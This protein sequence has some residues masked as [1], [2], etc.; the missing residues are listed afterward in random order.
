MKIQVDRDALAD[1]VAWTARALP[2]RPAIPVLACM[3]LHAGD[4]LTLSSFDY[5]V[6][7]QASVP[8]VAEEEGTVLV[9]GRLLAEITRSLPARP[10]E[11]SAD[12]ARATLG[13][14]AADAP[15]CASCRTPRR[16]GWQREKGSVLPSVYARDGC[17]GA[18]RSAADKL[19]VVWRSCA[20][21]A[22]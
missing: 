20:G 21:L 7:A 6:S 5:D 13:G 2:A 15:D 12:G 16:A 18:S 1:A 22:V 3:R 11:I 8:V 10:V 14:C 17:K 4:D 19:L 9:S